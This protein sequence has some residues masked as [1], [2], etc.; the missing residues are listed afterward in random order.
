MASESDAVCDQSVDVSANLACDV[1]MALLCDS[2]VS[3][4]GLALY[5]STIASISFTMY[6]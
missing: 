3:V 5:A 4:M 2:F 6:V 1:C